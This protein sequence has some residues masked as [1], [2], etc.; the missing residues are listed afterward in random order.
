MVDFLDINILRNLL[1]VSNNV[2]KMDIPEHLLILLILIIVFSRDG[3]SMDGQVG[4]KSDLS[5][6]SMFNVQSLINFIVRN[7]HSERLL[8]SPAVQIR[9]AHQPAELKDQCFS[10][11]RPQDC[12]GFRRGD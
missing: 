3:I 5:R 6:S 12:Q 11:Q 4:Q 9:Q 1:K 10:P 7:R 2:S 8:P